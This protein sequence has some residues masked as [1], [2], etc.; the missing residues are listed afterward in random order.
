LLY[1]LD[2]DSYKDRPVT[3]D[4]FL[5]KDEFLGKVLTKDDGT[6]SI[7]KFWR[8]VLT[9]LYPSPFYSPYF[10]VI[11]N[12][13][14]GSGKSVISS[15][16]LCYE[17]YRMQC[18]KSPQKYYGIFPVD[19]PIV[20]S[21][22]SVFRYLASDVN[23]GVFESYLSGSEWFVEHCM[24]K[25]GRWMNKTDYT[26]KMPNN[27]VIDLGYGAVSVLGKAV[28]GGS[29]DEANFYKTETKKITGS[30]K[31]QEAY[32]SL[33]RR[34]ES[35]FLQPDGTLPGKLWLTSSPKLS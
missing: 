20:F 17:L 22:F 5:E 9:D 8:K 1:I 33:I 13:P 12:L 14:I 24:P 26:C 28:F 2:R 15:S 7:Y 10:E 3:I 18:L 6:H 29:L 27:I 11:C 23:W 16:S 4:E 31:A 21:L 32:L 25:N 19:T 30:D 35:R 34:M